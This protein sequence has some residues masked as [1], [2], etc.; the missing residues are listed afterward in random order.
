[1]VQDTEKR[2]RLYVE[3]DFGRS[4]PSAW[5]WLQIDGRMTG[6]VHE[7]IDAELDV[8]LR[9]R[10]GRTIFEGT[11]RQAGLETQKAEDL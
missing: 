4:F 10:G 7:S 5:L 8:A 3:K 9:R 6:T 2:G 1:V 11:G